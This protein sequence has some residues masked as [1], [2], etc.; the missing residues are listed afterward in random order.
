MDALAHFLAALILAPLLPGIIN[1]VKARL[2]GRVGR[3]LLQTYFDLARL[4]RKGVVESETSSWMLP[5]G[6][7]VS[8]A[9]AAIALT[10]LPGPAGASPAAFT[11]DFILAAYCLGLGRLALI[12]AALD[13]GSSFEGMGASR[14]AAFSALAE[15]VL[16]LCLLA[17]AA[18]APD[19]SL[20][21][22]LGQGLTG[23]LAPERLFV[24]V[25]LFILLLTEN[26][27]IPVDDPN[28]HLELTMI[29]EVMVLDH[30]GPDMAAIVYGSCL[31]LWFFA[32]ATALSVL[33]VRAM[34]PLAGWAV[35]LAGMVVVAGAVGLVESSMARL[36]LIRVPRLLGAAGTLA[37][38][39]LVLTVW[40]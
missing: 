17:L 25:I 34:E 11:G 39:S 33:P 26:C 35:F 4:V 21:G 36:R 30:S 5:L 3:P 22:M 20:S 8:L 14:E 9:T 24:P 6:P 38:L 2:S 28:T 23:D 29:H 16:F 18:G 15:P 7:V 12:L 19:I 10:L 40:R 27:R 32:A 37:A 13:S 31:K 1:R